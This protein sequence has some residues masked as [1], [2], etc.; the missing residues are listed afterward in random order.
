VLLDENVT[1]ELE[2]EGL[3]RDVIRVV[4][5]ARRDA[6]LEV[7]DRI[8]LT[9]DVPPEL[10]AALGPHLAFLARETLAGTTRFGPLSGEGTFTGEAGQGQRV[11]VRVERA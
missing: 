9:L 1:P 6:G 10:A 5:L 11:A 2:A 3:A 7:S 8:A 4:Q